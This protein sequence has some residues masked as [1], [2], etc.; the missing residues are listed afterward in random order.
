MKFKLNDEE[1]LRA[2]EGLISDR[3]LAVLEANLKSFNVM[4]IFGIKVS[5]LAFSSF[6]SWLLNPTETHGL[7]DYFLKYFLIEC[8]K[9][10][11]EY[12]K[13]NPKID[14][15]V[16]DID[17]LNLN[18]AIVKTEEYFRN[19]R[20]DITVKISDRKYKFL[21]LIENKVKSTESDDQTSDY[22]NFSKD[23]YPGYQYMYI[24]LAPSDLE[25]DDLSS[26][27]FLLLTYEDVLIILQETLKFK[28]DI[29]NEEVIFLI[30]QFIKNLE[31][32]VLERENI[33]KL[34]EEI[35][36]KHKKAIDLILSK[37]PDY[38][39]TI[40]KKLDENLKKNTK[41]IKWKIDQKPKAIHV[42]QE[43]WFDKFKDIWKKQFPFFLYK[44]KSKDDTG[45]QIWIE[46]DIYNVELR[47]KFVE[48]LEASLSKFPSAQK[49]YRE[50][51][52][53]VKFKEMILTESYESDD[54][55]FEHIQLDC[56][57]KTEFKFPESNPDLFDKYYHYAKTIK[58]ILINEWDYQKFIKK[59][60]HY[61]LY[62]I[63]SKLKDISNHLQNKK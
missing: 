62:S 23:K 48:L 51:K 4:E 28:R 7:D 20:A 30:E 61:L 54:D 3:N 37:R 26:E 58:D 56:E 55:L 41:G 35:Y 11:E 21:C 13:L 49:R 44:I 15:Q 57:F 24:Y 14:L 9:R 52:V 40:A 38:I 25:Y 8:I 53:A 43:H 46:F 29:L 47:K 17:L 34:C 16:I 39:A 27:E 22:A 12:I 36:I 1:A 42:F 45:S 5:E 2:L 31:V 19:R 32:N 18:L 10:N 6:I 33:D 59:L 50:K 60:P 63:D